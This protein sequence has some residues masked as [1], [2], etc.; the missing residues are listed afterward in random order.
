[1]SVDQGNA[2]QAGL[3]RRDVKIGAMARRPAGPPW[4]SW[5]T[6][7][8]GLL[9]E[10]ALSGDGRPRPAWTRW[11]AGNEIA[12]AS[13]AEAR[14]LPAVAANLAALAP[15]EA[16]AARLRG[17]ARHAWTAN[18]VRA[19]RLAGA[20][21]A[22]TAA[23]VEVM[24]L[25]GAAMACTLA[26]GMRLR[27]MDDVDLLVRERDVERA[28]EVLFAR[29]FQPPQR[30]FLRTRRCAHAAAFFGEGLALD[31]HWR[32]H[33]RVGGDE[34]DLWAHAGRAMLADR[35]LLVPASADRFVHAC[36]HGLGA[37][38]L[39][40]V[41]A[42][43]CVLT[44]RAAPLDWSRIVSIARAHRG[45]ASV[46]EATRYMR[47]RGW[48][49]VPETALRALAAT[50]APWPARLEDR[51]MLHRSV[52]FLLSTYAALF[53]DYRALATRRGARPSPGGFLSFLSD[54]SAVDRRRDLPRH[55]LRRAR[56][57]SV[58]LVA[59]QVERAVRRSDDQRI[60]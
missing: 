33:H 20:L 7:D 32:P 18:Q 58:R 51:V 49:E 27:P 47:D 19:R 15:A 38:R 34:E 6:N 17:I 14:L 50:H 5:P 22:F 43:D 21:D 26:G 29:G 25:K 2:S 46:L 59:D 55:W 3:G 23:G 30:G 12:T 53:G 4:R 44:S 42:L 41:W 35:S 39:G 56:Q 16:D 37:E 57:R 28:V 1:M 31:L 54:V 11:R 45:A 8:E 10:A 9:L 60:V 52:P 13:A 36:L 48:L 24:A 40:P